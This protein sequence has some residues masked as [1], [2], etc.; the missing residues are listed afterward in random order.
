MIM[1]E[2]IFSGN[3]ILNIKKAHDN[4]KIKCLPYDVF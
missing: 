3:F 2:G 4:R 1:M